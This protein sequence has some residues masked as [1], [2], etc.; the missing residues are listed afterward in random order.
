MSNLNAA[1]L[2]RRDQLGIE[3]AMWRAIE[4]SKKAMLCVG[5]SK[6]RNA[7]GDEIFTIRH[8]RDAIPAFSFYR[9]KIDV[10][11]RVLEILRASA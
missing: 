2:S 9:G 11:P 4:N 6:A 3:A 7:S 8:D 5:F 10:T 1:A